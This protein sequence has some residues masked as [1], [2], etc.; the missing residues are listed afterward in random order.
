MAAQSHEQAL[1]K[2]AAATAI[3]L[4]AERELTGRG[5]VRDGSSPRHWHLDRAWWCVNVS[6]D[7][8]FYSVSV[9][10]F[11]GRQNLWSP[12]PAHHLSD[13]ERWGPDHFE[14]YLLGRLDGSDGDPAAVAA[15]YAAEAARR[16]VRIQTTFPDD[17]AHLQSL[18]RIE[19][20][21]PARDGTPA[22]PSG[23]DCLVGNLDDVVLS[24]AL[25][26]RLHVCRQV[27]AAHRHNLERDERNRHEHPESFAR[28]VAELDDL[29]A[30]VAA[31]DPRPLIAERINTGRALLKMAPMDP[32]PAVL[33]DAPPAP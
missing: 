19:Y 11:V 5:L 33:T 26:G 6:L 15:S 12:F 7:S 24:N 30:L 27:L 1:M 4:A 32:W 16:V 9:R 25:L 31:D 29:D 14:P 22:D 3:K 21:T 18:T 8:S 2:R 17:W 23:K 10:L 13:A 20:L 28:E